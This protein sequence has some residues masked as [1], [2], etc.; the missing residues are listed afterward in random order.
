[1][2]KFIDL[3]NL[4][5]NN[6]ECVILEVKEDAFYDLIALGCFTGN[7]TLFRVT[8]GGDHTMTVWDKNHKEFSFHWGYSGMSLVSDNLHRMRKIVYDTIVNEFDIVMEGNGID[9]TLGLDV[10]P[11]AH[12]Y[13]VMSWQKDLETAKDIVVHKDNLFLKIFPTYQDVCK[14]FK[15]KA[16]TVKSTY[17]AQTGCFVEVWE[18]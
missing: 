11:K 4:K 14:F 16:I 5:V 8:K 9:S 18:A 17:R 7:E 6:R 3:V 15:G 1:M 2:K 13:K 10:K 12:E